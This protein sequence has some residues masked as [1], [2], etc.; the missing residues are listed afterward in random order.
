M[1]DSLDFTATPSVAQA[2]PPAPAASSGA[3]GKLS[4]RLDALDLNT[5]PRVSPVASKLAALNPSEME[6]TK[7]FCAIIEQEPICVARLIG[8]AN[9]VAF[10]IPG[11][12]FNALDQAV[13][14]IGLERAAQTAFGMLCGQALN[15]G[16]SPQWREFL[17]LHA[18]AVA[19]GASMLATKAAPAERANAYLGGMIYDIGTLVIECLQPGT[20]DLLLE[21]AVARGMKLGQV[22]HVMLGKARRAVSTALLRKWSLP[23]EIIAAVAERDFD[24]IEPDSLAAIL[25]VADELAR[26][27][28]VMAAV[29][30][31]VE[32][33]FPLDA[34]MLDGVSERTASL[35]SLDAGVIET[36]GER[37]SNQVM[38]LRATAESFSKAA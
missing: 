37:L 26:S 6:S 21:T 10:G 13:S 16:L 7:V 30:S 29:Y 5:L 17:W 20:L 4:D 23:D 14:R 15:K 33:P 8:L 27:E 22:E 1:D 25:A 9:S 38:A 35:L 12:K 18:M 31:E 34:I 2:P 19:H 36:V 32:P 11:K 3:L 28:V 24:L